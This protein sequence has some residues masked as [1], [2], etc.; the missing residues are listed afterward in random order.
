MRF[1]DGWNAAGPGS[2]QGHI[3]NVPAMATPPITAC[4]RLGRASVGS[5]DSS[6][7]QVLENVRDL[8]RPRYVR[9]MACVHFNHARVVHISNR[10]TSKW[11]T[12][13]EDKVE[14]T[15]QRSQREFVSLP[16]AHLNVRP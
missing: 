4:R 2:H 1:S 16:N 11:I 14:A 7:C 12:V 8:S 3:G 5:G 15:F 6:G 9:A 13:T 10:Q